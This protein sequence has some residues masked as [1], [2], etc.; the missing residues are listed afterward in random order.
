MLAVG[1]LTLSPRTSV[2]HGCKEGATSGFLKKIFF[3]YQVTGDITERSKALES[4][5]QVNSSPDICLASTMYQVL[6]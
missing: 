3:F 2:P 6:F 1:K 4:V 5:N